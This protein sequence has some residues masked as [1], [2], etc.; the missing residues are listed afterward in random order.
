MAA[1]GVDVLLLGRESNVRYVSGA[2]RL[3][4]AGTRPFSPSCVVV[5][6]TGAVHLLSVTDDGVPAAVP[7]ERLY[8][9]SWNPMNLVDA[10]TAATAGVA[11]RRIGV[12]GMSPLFEQLLRGGFGN[13]ELVDGEALLREVRRVKSAADVDGIRAAVETTQAALAAVIAASAGTRD[14]VR[15][16]GVASVRLGELG[17]TTPDT[18]PEVLVADDRVAARV[19]ALRDGWAGVIARTWP[20]PEP[21]ASTV[22]DATAACRPGAAVADLA[23]SGVT[24]EGLG[25]GHEELSADARLEAGMVVVVA[26][27]T[28]GAGWADTVLVTSGAPEVLTRA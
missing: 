16:R 24:V 18:E 17:V 15:L 10:A 3:W 22:A 28:D 2:N 27:G 19:G 8:P 7:H 25:L 13:I 11:V 4:L 5:G 20:G 21:L 23:A 6:E 9:I 1:A 12:D 26:A 14:P